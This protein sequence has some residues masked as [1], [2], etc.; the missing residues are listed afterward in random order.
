MSQ[1]HEMAGAAVDT[2]WRGLYGLGGLA[3]LTIVV[4]TAFQVV[5]FV[6]SP[7][8]STVSGFFALLQKNTLLGL[9]S[10]DLLLMADYALWGLIYLAF[11][12]VLRKVAPSA[13]V[14]ATAL[15]LLGVAIYFSSNTAFNMLA[16]SHVYSAA[17]AEAQR[18]AAVA[19]G[20][21]MLAI[22]EGT[23]FQV[24]YFF[25]SVA[26]LAIAF[27][28]L[29]SAIFSK[30]TAWVGIAGNI[31]GFGMFVPV[32]GIWLATVSVVVLAVWNVMFARSLLRLW[33]L[34]AASPAS[35]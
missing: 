23:A 7:P 5:V 25:L 17:T 19:A 34:P 24:S 14:V 6:V 31:L 22:Y 3:A 35:A 12:A 27:V 8:P 21:G 30:A 26:P 15:G 33:R 18:A 32:A 9:L 1:T 11:Y 28:M 4:L 13:M 16:L 10:M 2:R 29:R 20:Q